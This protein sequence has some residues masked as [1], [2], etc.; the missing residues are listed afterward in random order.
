MVKFDAEGFAAMMGRIAD[1]EQAE[2]AAGRYEE[3]EPDYKY[4][5]GAGAHVRLPLKGAG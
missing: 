5:P 4:M 1:E 2:A 3:I